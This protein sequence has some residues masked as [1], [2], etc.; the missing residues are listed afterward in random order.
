MLISTQRLIREVDRCPSSFNDYSLEAQLQRALKH[1]PLT[2]TA[3][4][5]FEL[6]EVIG[7]ATSTEKPQA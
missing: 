1:S 3:L 7:L 6:Q 4:T 2:W 5:K